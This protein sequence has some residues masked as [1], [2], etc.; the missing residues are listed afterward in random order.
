MILIID[1]TYCWNTA[2]DRGSWKVFGGLMGS[3]LASYLQVLVTNTE[4]TGDVN[5]LVSLFQ[6][7]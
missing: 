4:L 6:I 1:Y 7:V 2:I 5:L 3:T